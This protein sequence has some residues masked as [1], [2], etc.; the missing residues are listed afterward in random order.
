MRGTVVLQAAPRQGV[1]LAGGDRLL[2]GHN[3]WSTSLG[4]VHQQTPVHQAMY[5]FAL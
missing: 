2:V 1:L 5:C 3:G 4:H